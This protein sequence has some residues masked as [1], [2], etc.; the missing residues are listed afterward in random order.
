MLV[1]GIGVRSAVAAAA[2]GRPFEEAPEEEVPAD[3]EDGVDVEEEEADER[4][5]VL[6]FLPPLSDAL[7]P[8]SPSLLL[9]LMYLLGQSGSRVSTIA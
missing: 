7:S 5:E 9:C 8:P 6:Y 2:E 4:V 3:A 1:L